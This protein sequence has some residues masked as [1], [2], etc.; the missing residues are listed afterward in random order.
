MA[1]TVTSITPIMGGRL[2]R[3]IY[4]QD[5]G[6]E[7]RAHYEA[8]DLRRT[9]EAMIFDDYFP[10]WL[11]RAAGEARIALKDMTLAQFRT[12]VVGKT[13]PAVPTLDAAKT[14]DGV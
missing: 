12:L 1:Y 3:V 7:R 5:G 13:L 10:L 8:S 4:T 2:L 14:A 11:R 6:P 9:T